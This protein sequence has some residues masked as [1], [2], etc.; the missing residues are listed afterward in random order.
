MIIQHP[1]AIELIAGSIMRATH[2]LLID[3]EIVSNEST[4]H[5]ALN[6]TI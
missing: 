4:S 1:P 5:S 3:V 6:E 2:S